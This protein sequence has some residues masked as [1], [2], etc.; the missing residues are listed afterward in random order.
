[1]SGK[2]RRSTQSSRSDNESAARSAP[3][4]SFTHLVKRPGVLEAAVPDLVDGPLGVLNRL[5]VRVVLD[6]EDRAALDAGL[7]LLRKGVVA[8]LD[9]AGP[10]AVAGQVGGADLGP[11][12]L[13]ATPPEAR[14]I[15]GGSV[16]YPKE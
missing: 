10:A 6:G 15:D 4:A 14:G 13:W 7:V 9:L 8:T 1:M 16:E 5:A 11:C 12:Q 3:L 2:T